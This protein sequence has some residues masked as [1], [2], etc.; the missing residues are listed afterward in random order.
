M[1]EDEAYTLDE[2]AKMLGITVKTLKNRCYDGVN[3][4]PYTDLTHARPFP[5]AEYQRWCQSKLKRAV[6]SA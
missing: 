3:H 6:Q 5:K 1:S 2:M 4:P